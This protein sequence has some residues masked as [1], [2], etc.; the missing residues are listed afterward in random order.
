[1]NVFYSEIIRF[2][3]ERNWHTLKELSAAL[4]ERGI[5]HD[6]KHVNK[7]LYYPPK[8]E[9]ELNAIVDIFGAEKEEIKCAIELDSLPYEIIKNIRHIP[10]TELVN[11][12]SEESQST[13]S[14]FCSYLKQ[15]RECKRFTYT[16]LAM[17]VGVSSNY[18]YWLEKGE[19]GIPEPSILKRIAVA[20][21]APYEEI[22]RKAGY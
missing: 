19:R 2:Y 21:G 3:N 17:S 22:M 12:K 15:H 8:T 1:M 20:V 14:N 18:I 9:Q 13:L 5:S 7:F 16:A 10:I 4:N 11:S 6:S